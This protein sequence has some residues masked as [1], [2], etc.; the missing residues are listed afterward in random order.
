MG[1]LLKSKNLLTV[2]I[3][4][5]I[6]LILLVSSSFLRI[7][8]KTIQNEY[9]AIKNEIVGLKANPHI[10]VVELDNKSFESLWS[11]PFSRSIYA[12][13]LENLKKYNTAVVAFD[14]LFLDPSV[15]TEDEIF[16]TAISR[17]PN[18][19][20]GS[21][22]NSFGEVITPFSLLKKESYRTGFLSPIVESSN[23]TVY[24]FSPL[25][26]DIKGN[27]Y[28]HFTLQILRSFY[29]YLYQDT[30]KMSLWNYESWEYVFSD[31]ISYPLSSKDSKE[32][33]INFI[34]S[35]NFLRVSFSD[36]YD[37]IALKKIDRDIG[38]QDK[39]LIIGPAAD[40]LKDIF[41][42]PNGVEY[43]VNIH[44]NILNTLLSKKYMTYFDAHLEWI[45][46]FFLIIL[47]VSANLS[48]SNRIL[49]LSN[50]AIVL[51]FWIIIPLSILLGTNLILNY[52]SE[53][54]F[55]LLLAF[56]SANIVKYLI[57]DRNKQKLNK[58][59]SEYVGS[60]IAEEI[61]LEAGKINLDGQE[62]N[63]VCFFSDIEGFTSLSEKLSPNELVTFLR[64]Y[65]SE[66]T[67]II[68]DKR[69]HV[70]K[71]EWDA[72]MALWG[73]FTNHSKSDFIAACESAIIQ[74]KALEKINNKWSKK[75]WKKI[76]I[77][78][79]IHGWRAIIWNI[80]AIG[81]KME[82]T[83]LWD[84]IN[85]A[86]RLEWV[87]KF[88]G[89]FICVSE[90]VYKAWK[91]FF[92]FRY[93]DEIQVKGKDIPVKIYELLWLKETTLPKKRQIQNAFIWA[94]RLYKERNFSDAKD[95]FERLA[96]EGDP[97]SKTYIRRCEYYIKTPPPENWDGVWRMEDK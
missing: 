45:M 87:N 89:T 53:I 5:I 44:A 11:F 78:I 41:F 36:L 38:L 25:I 66:M 88:Y 39:I 79:G 54:I 65:L 80:G 74:Q 17:Y 33:L 3:S 37:P 73:A 46:I 86:S 59:L 68:M 50:G 69:W 7:L 82:F 1:T 57:E 20:L 23:K 4:C 49:L 71:F 60:N 40:G 55:S 94:L 75:L 83:A 30:K 77:R 92:D 31:T 28:E 42:T 64:E 72:I 61:L 47:S 48:S 9:Y 26:Q 51:V 62:K 8:N 63:L 90:V 15:S 52:P 21:S 29:R 22:L 81:R 10:V 43:G 93:L 12:K 96:E 19:V 58:A 85:L 18:I 2:I 95:V 91:D 14:M 84:N 16:K 67:S 13:V 76:K 34:P 24:S 97:P 56:T 27:K 70:D 35:T 32:I 6:V